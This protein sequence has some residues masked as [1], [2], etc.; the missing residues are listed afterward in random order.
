MPLTRSVTRGRLYAAAMELITRCTRDRASYRFEGTAEVSPEDPA[1]GY[2]AN[3]L[4]LR[5]DAI[6]AIPVLADPAGNSTLR[7]E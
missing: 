2:G 3:L 5:L 6:K 4:H 1:G 7:T